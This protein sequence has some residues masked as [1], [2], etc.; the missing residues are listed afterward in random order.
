MEQ[1]SVHE[2]ISTSLS[3][4]QVYPQVCITASHDYKVFNSFRRHPGYTQILEHVTKELGSEYLRILS[5]D[6]DIF[7]KMNIF[8]LN[9]NYGN[10]VMYEYP[11]VGLISPTTLRYI[12]VLADIKKYFH[13]A[14]NLNICEIGVGYGGQCRLI[15]AYYKPASYRLVDIQPALALTQTYLDNFILNSV[16]S[17]K[18][19]NELNNK[20]YDLVI[21]NYAFTEL[22]RAVQDVYLRKVILNSKR[23]YITY[24]E[25]TPKEYNSYK[26]DELLAIIP[27]SK[28][29]NEEPLTYLKNCLIVWG[30]NT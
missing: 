21:S 13:T 9:D 27:G 1:S 20:F 17:Y 10:P 30:E 22:P 5:N 4:N 12:K 15:N 18:T 2:H 28:V 11:N 19:M 25:I 29:F 24:N 6:P 14:D 23:G 3:D 7:A 8:K 26:S 16:L